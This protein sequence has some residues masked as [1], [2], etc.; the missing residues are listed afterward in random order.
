MSFHL[1]RIEVRLLRHMIQAGL[2]I[3]GVGEGLITKQYVH[4][5]RKNM[6]Q[7]KV[8]CA[9][10]ENLQIDCMQRVIHTQYTVTDLISTSQQSVDQDLI[11][12][13]CKCVSIPH[14]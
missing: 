1:S 8:N 13:K 3:T 9:A 11:L 6:L 7:G 5:V 10:W 14:S 4:I 12:P 2:W